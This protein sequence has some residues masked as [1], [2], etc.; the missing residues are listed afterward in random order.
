MIKRSFI[1]KRHKIKENLELM[2][3][4]MCEPFLVHTWGKYEHFITSIDEYSRF[5]YVYL[6]HSKSNFLNKFFEF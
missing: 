2:H 6:V 5:G 3:T 4:N 1:S